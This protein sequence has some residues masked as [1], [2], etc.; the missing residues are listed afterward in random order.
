MRMVVQMRKVR[1]PRWKIL[2]AKLFNDKPNYL[3]TSSYV[4]MVEVALFSRRPLRW[5][6][7]LKY[8][9][10]SVDPYVCKEPHLLV[11][12]VIL[13]QDSVHGREMIFRE[14]AG[15]LKKKIFQCQFWVVLL[16]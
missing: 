13:G 7:K 2:K 1:D 14:S 6:P 10:S 9:L 15:N 5:C 8:K 3:L 4:V 11:E 12:V 16:E